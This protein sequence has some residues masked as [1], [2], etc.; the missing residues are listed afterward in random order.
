M[1]LIDF[2]RQA[3]DWAA[4]RVIELDRP[5][6]LA[7]PTRIGWTAAELVVH[8][9]G[10]NV[11]CRN[12][13]L[14]IGPEALGDPSALAGD[15]PVGAH[16]RSSAALTGAFADPSMY[17]RVLPTPVGP[18]PGATVLTVGTLE[19]LVHAWDLTAAASAVIPDHL[20]DEA[21]ARITSLAALFDQF[22]GLGFYGPARPVEPDAD[23]QERLLAFLGRTA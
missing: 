14:G 18:H 5:A 15:D 20:V 12:A 13:T 10:V 8:L 22:R 11:M 21:L 7:A 16:S 17:D 9:V 19:N 2:H 23:R 1:H 6:A 4:G 3:M